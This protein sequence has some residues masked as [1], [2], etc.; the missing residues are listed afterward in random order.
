MNGTTHK[1][2]SLIEIM[3][4]VA[5]IGVLAAVAIP[6]YQDYVENSN[7]SK[8]TVHFEEGARFVENSLRKVQA[9]LA[10]GRI[11]NLAAAD[12]SGDYTQ[13]GLV[14]QL[15]ANGGAA[16]G[17]GAAYV[18]GAG[19]GSTGAVGVTVTGTFA[20]GDWAATLDRPVIYAF[21]APLSRQ[22]SWNDI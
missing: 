3:V 6:A 15:N 16:P 22:A 11:A 17:G 4:V 8:V 1:G 5:I 21:T 2:F 20:A 12:A 14:A 19:D 9:D 10:V 18:E 7:M 13:A